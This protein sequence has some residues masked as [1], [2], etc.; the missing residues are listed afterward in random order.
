MT[1]SI[2]L[3]E[4]QGIASAGVQFT[5]ESDPRFQVVA[6]AATLS[7]ARILIEELR[8]EFIILDVF[9]TDGSGLDLLEEIKRK[10]DS[11]IKIIVYSGQANP[12]EFAVALQRGA[13]AIVSKGDDP[14]DLMEALSHLLRNENYQ[15]VSVQRMLALSQDGELTAREQEVLQL[16]FL[17]LDSKSIGERLNTS[18]ATVRKHRE[19]ILNKLNAPNT[20]AAVRHGIRMGIIDINAR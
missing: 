9:L 18:T 20:V 19:N 3:V 14:G 11:A 13:D 12:H 6:T 5:L 2:L 4:D 17:G 7:R 10:S 15:S 1:H 16:L 8:P